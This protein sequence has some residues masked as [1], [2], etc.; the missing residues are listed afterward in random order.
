[1]SH[2]WPVRAPRP[3]AEKLL[4]NSPLLTGQR[5]LDALF[6]SVRGGSYVFSYLKRINFQVRVPFPEP[7]VAEKRSFLK[8]CPNIPTRTASFTSVVE[9]VEMKWQKC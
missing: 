1:M 4:A 3:V 6:P 9:N 5:V 8:P 2:N 7:L